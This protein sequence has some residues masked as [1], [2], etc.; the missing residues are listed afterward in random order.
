M[1]IHSLMLLLALAIAL[2][3]RSFLP[4]YQRRWQISLFFFLFPPLLLVMT[5]IAVICMGYGGQMFGYHENRLSYVLALAWIS[6]ALFSLIQRYYQADRA[7]KYL[8]NYPRAI[9][10]GQPARIIDL[11][12]PYSARVGLWDSELVITRGL[13][14]L[15]DEEH[16]SSV[17]AHESAH[18]DY[19]DTF[20]FFWLGWARSFSAWLPNTEELWS[21]LVFLRELRADNHAARSVDPLLLAESLLQVARKVNQVSAIEFPAECCATLADESLNNRLLERID[22]LVEE[23]TE[24][25]RF[26]WQVW[27]LLSFSLAPFLLLPWHS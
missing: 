2:G 20:W 8:E 9:V 23:E 19:R 26:C 24:S 17:L 6:F 5:A 16:L 15:L 25:P 18:S 14:E 4:T 3:L 22:A 11:D 13:L 21:E 1:A 12:F 27:V 7:R 10:E